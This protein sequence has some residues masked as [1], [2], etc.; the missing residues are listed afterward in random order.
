MKKF[1]SLILILFLSFNSV[2]AVEEI[3]LESEQNVFHYLSDVYYGKVENASPVLKLFSEKGLE[4]ENSPINSLKFTFLYSSEFTFLDRER[5]NGSFIHDFATAEP[6]VTAKFNNNK[7]TAMFDLNLLRNLDGYSNDFSQKISKVFIAH[8][9]T[10]NQKI[11]IGQGNRVPS[12]YNGSRGT[13]DQEMVLRSQLGRT[14][15]NAFSVG[16]R[17]KGSYKYLEYDIGLYDSTRYMKDF[18]HGM[19]FTSYFMFKPLSNF[20]DK[21]GDVRLGTGYGVGDYYNNYSVYSFFLGYDKDKFHFKTEFADADGYNGV[22]CSSNK[23]N[24]F[25]TTISYDITPRFTIIGRYDYLNQNKNISHDSSQEFTA[26]FTYHMF[27]NLKFML[28]FVRAE[29][30]NKSDSNMI[31]FATRFII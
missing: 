21:I 20:K 9:I 14:Y 5:V 25:Y 3:H 31:L 17:N 30:Q 2:A 26:G 10:E 18:G 16:I 22:K 7:T 24:G 27:K 19:D 6:M 1:F 13:M 4:F 8:E 12:T 28:N 11:I 15:G 23:S 29:H